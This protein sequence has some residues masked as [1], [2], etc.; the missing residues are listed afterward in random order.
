M[1]SRAL[2]RV[3]PDSDSRSALVLG[4]SERQAAKLTMGFTVPSRA[5]PPPS[6]PTLLADDSEAHV[7]VVAPTGAGKGRNFIIPNLLSTK[8]PCIVLDIKGE[9]ARVTARYRR[10]IGHD[11]VILDP[12]H[13]ATDEPATLNPL[14]RVTRNRGTVA[15]EAFMLAS[16]LSEGRRF[17]RDSFWDD[18]GEAL[19]AGLFT[20]VA[21]SAGLKSRALGDV[22]KL[23]AS[24]DFVYSTAVLIDNAKKLHPF[25]KQQLVG[26]LGHEERVRSSVLS[27]AKQHMR[28]FASDAVQRSVAKTS[29]DLSKVTTGAPLTVYIVIPP[30]KIASHSMLLRMWLSTLLGIITERTSAPQLPTIFMVDELAQ[31]GGLRAFKEAV[32]LLRGYGLRC[33]LFL[34]SHAQLRAIYPL[35]HESITENCGAIVTFGHQKYPMSQQMS[36]LLGDITPDALFDMTPEQIAVQQGANPTVVARRVDYL[37]DSLFAGRADCNPLSRA[38]QAQRTV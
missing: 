4:W 35:D 34:Q 22:W 6:A 30:T 10:A 7:L 37:T 17:E 27:V 23:L 14:D 13:I 1:R 18:H 20:Y 3:Q 29:F 28:V 2:K 11:V 15:D 36:E 5:E 16:L 21:T 33:C 24:S 25:A 31:L 12:F 26:F 19:L 38:S 8:S 9:A 32:T